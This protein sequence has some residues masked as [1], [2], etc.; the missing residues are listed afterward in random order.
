MV[1]PFNWRNLIFNFFGNEGV[2]IFWIPSRIEG[3]NRNHTEV[4]FW[5]GFFRNTVGWVGSN[6]NNKDQNENYSPPLFNPKSKKNLP[7]VFF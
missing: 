4:D 6:E 5:K 3:C 7:E 2:N 1:N